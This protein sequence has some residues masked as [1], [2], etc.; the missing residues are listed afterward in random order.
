MFRQVME[1]AV[2][3]KLPVK[4][5]KSLYTKWLSFEEKFGG[6]DD[7]ERVKQA[8]VQYINKVTSSLP[9]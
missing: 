8:A 4:K 2:R 3:Q 5:M 7:V 1:R 6:V 9:V